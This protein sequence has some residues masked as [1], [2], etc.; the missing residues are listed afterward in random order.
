MRSIASRCGAD[1]RRVDVGPQRGEPLLVELRARAEIVECPREHDDA[2]VDPLAAL[3]ARHDAIHGVGERTTVAHG[4]SRLPRRMFAAPRAGRAGTQRRPRGRRRRATRRESRRRSPRAAPR[5][6]RAASRASASTIDEA[7]GSSTCSPIAGNGVAFVPR[8]DA[9][10][11]GGSRARRH[12]RSAI[13]GRARAAGSGSARCGRRSSRARRTT[14]RRRRDRRREPISAAGLN[15]SA[16][17]RKST[18]RFRPALAT[19]R[20]WIS[21]SGSARPSTGSSS[22]SVNSGTAKPSARAS[23]PATISAISA[24]RPCPA[25]R[26]FRT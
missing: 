20:S 23:S 10:S 25:P 14:R 15:G 17:G 12:G 21:G 5:V 9:R 26:N 1:R 22:T 11:R 3:D 24:F 8:R 2:D 19:S 13:A 7:K 6:T 18:P 4:L 16:D